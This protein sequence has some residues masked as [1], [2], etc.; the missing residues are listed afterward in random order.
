MRSKQLLQLLDKLG[1][2]RR[3][4]GKET[5]A[6]IDFANW[7][8][9]HK[10]LEP[11]KLRAPRGIRFHKPQELLKLSATSSDKVRSS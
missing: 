8:L 10:R 11:P 1:D 6:S 4:R 7:G 3:E 5:V 2:R 9:F